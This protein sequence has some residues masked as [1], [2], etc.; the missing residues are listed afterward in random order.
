MH[1]EI[2]NSLSAGT[3]LTVH[4]KLKDDDLGTRQVM[5]SWEFSFKPSLLVRTLFF[6]SFSWPRRFEHFDIYM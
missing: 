4:C 5:D 3:T 2:Q 6:C 1:V